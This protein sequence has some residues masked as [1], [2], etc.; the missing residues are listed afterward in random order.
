MA[1]VREGLKYTESD[2]WIKT[3]NG[4]IRMGI[5]DFAQGKLTDIVGVWDLL[6]TGTDISKGDVICTIESVKA[7][8]EMYSPVNGKIIEVNSSLEDE[9]E[10]V[11]SDP[12]GD[13]WFVVIELADP[14]ELDTL[15]DPDPYKAR[16]EE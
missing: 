5:T 10:K 7:S 11:N 13:G 9:P 1:E 6:E 3:E 16:T 2:E 4:N 15:M 12:Y 8:A 14:G